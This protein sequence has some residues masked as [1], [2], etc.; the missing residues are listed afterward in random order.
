MRAKGR[1]QE[2][3]RQ[4]QMGWEQGDTEDAKTQTLILTDTL[5]NTLHYLINMLY[6]S[7]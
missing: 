4:R 3:E 7:K 5:P 1:E 6:M 2:R